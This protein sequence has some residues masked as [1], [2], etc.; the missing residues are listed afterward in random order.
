VADLTGRRVL[1][2]G[3]SKGIG[4]GVAR[5]LDHEGAHVAIAAR[6]IGLLEQLASECDGRPT[7]I[8]CDVREARD[9]AA[10]VDA[11]AEVLG[12]LDVLVYAVGMGVVASLANATSEHWMQALETNVVG[13]NLVT[14][15][16]VP[17]LASSSGVAV[18]FSSV[19]AQLTP[20]WKG[21]GVYLA[22]KKALEKS[23]Q[24][25]TLE[26]PAVRF[27]TII[28][29]STSGGSFF[30]DAAIPEPGDVA[31]FQADWHARGYL[32]REQ[33]DPDD[34]AQ[35]VVDV[36]ASRAQMDTVWVRPRSIMQLPDD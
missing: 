18:Y 14:A 36:I 9:C 5:R 2:V 30:D 12:G 19:S 4:R 25:W 31:G 26:E 35:A 16:A 33:L 28:V 7:V 10:A 24:V 13:A 17:H 21:M 6:N 23:V 15:A 34:Q 3:A 32:A 20:P 29:G 11:A 27:T 22:C 1:V 8:G